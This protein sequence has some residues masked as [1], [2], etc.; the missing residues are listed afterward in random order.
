MFS[1][2]KETMRLLADY[3][4]PADWRIDQFSPRLSLRHRRGRQ[5]AGAHFGFG[6]PGA[7]ARVVPAPGPRR[8]P[9]RHHPLLSCAPGRA[10][11]IPSMT[12]A[13]PRASSMWPKAD[14]RC[15]M[16][17]W[18]CPR[19]VSAR[20][21]DAALQPPRG[22]VAAAFHLHAGGPGGMFRL[23]VAPAGGLSRRPRIH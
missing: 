8:V 2:Q 13:P 14:C 10:C 5:M 22:V 19:M 15:R 1:R 23:P 20:L 17:S 4:C 16:T 12:A 18:P 9:F 6:Q 3:L 7:G 11:T 21:L